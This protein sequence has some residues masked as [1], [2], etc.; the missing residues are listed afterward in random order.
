MN[1]YALMGLGGDE[2]VAI[3]GSG[4]CLRALKK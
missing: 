1:H 4:G 2:A 3:G